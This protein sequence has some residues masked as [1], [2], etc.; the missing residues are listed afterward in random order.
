MF[1]R[2]GILKTLAIF[3]G[4]HLCR[5]LFFKKVVGLTAWNSNTGSFNVNIAKFSKTAFFIEHPGYLLL[6]NRGGGFGFEVPA[7]FMF[8]GTIRP[9]N[10]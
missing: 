2:I 10:G 6:M 4:K 9:S 5:S 7:D 1:Y 8:Y 3:P